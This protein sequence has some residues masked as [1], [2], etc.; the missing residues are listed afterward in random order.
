MQ[1]QEMNE[2]VY[3]DWVQKV[4]YLEGMMNDLD[5]N[6]KNIDLL[7]EQLKEMDSLKGGED[8][9]APVANGIFVEAKL[10]NSKTVKVNIGKGVM[11][12]KTIPET[13]EL[14]ERQE[15]EVILT[16]EQILMKL[17]EL[18]ELAKTY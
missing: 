13:I 1:E 16:R 9:L 14:I 7:K 18:Y 5:N 4:Q 3:Q 15:Q 12:D 6:M 10:K 11:V 8:I 2:S 17:G